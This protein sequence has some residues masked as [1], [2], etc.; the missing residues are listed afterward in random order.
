MSKIQL[1][2]TKEASQQIG[3]SKA[4]ILRWISNKLISDVEH[5][6]DNDYRIWSDTDIKR[7]IE[8]KNALDMEK[9]RK[10]RGIL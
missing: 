2:T 9:T 8:F 10:G 5:R 3:R 7:F 6:D 1:Y 4:T